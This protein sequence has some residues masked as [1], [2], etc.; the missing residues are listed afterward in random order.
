MPWTREAQYFA[1]LLTWRQNLSKL[2]KQNFAGSLITPEKPNLQL[3]TKISSHKVS[4]NLNKKA[5]NSRSGRKFTARCLNNMDV[6]R[7]SV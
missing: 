6:V 3:D 1:S 4:K 5:E 2:G 7:N